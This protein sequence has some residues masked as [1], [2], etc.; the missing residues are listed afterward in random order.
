MRHTY[1]ARKNGLQNIVKKD[2]GRAKQK[3]QG[4]ARRNFTKPRTSHFFNLCRYLRNRK[5]KVTRSTVCRAAETKLSHDG[6]S[7]YRVI[8]YGYSI[9]TVLCDSVPI[10]HDYSLDES[11]NVSSMSQWLKKQ[12]LLYRLLPLNCEKVFVSTRRPWLLS[13]IRE[14]LM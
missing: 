8:C 2:P 14:L 5:K 6:G 1:R 9:Q 12:K 11:Y 10:R 7:L 3:S 4:T 13:L